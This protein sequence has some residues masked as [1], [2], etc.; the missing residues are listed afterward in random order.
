MQTKSKAWNS[1]VK[2]IARTWIFAPVMATSFLAFTQPTE[3]FITN[4]ATASGTYSAST[5]TSAPSAVNIPV[6]LANPSLSIAKSIKTIA[7]TGL[8]VN[9]TITD[10]GDT[11]VYHYIITNNGNVTITG[12]TPVDAKPKFGPAQVT[13]TGAALVFTLTSGSTTLLP[14]QIAG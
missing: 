10:A 4:S 5:I 12:V 6:V 2:S 13:G 9:G 11:I 1:K 7:S 8:G 3:A 14:G